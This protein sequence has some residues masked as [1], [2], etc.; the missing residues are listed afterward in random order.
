MVFARYRLTDFEGR[1]FEADLLEADEEHEVL[2]KGSRG[3]GFRISGFGREPQL[4]LDRLLGP[5][6]AR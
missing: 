6:R 1:S 3:F 4:D 2:R 5:R